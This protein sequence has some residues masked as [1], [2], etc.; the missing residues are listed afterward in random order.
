MK[1]MFRNINT[2]T[3]AAMILWVGVTILLSASAAQSVMISLI[4]CGVVIL[5]SLT[6]MGQ[7]EPGQ[8]LRQ[9]QP[10][11]KFI[12]RNTA[13]PCMLLVPIAKCLAMEFDSPR[14]LLQG[15]QRPPG[16]KSR[17]AA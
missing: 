4:C 14:H 12:N 11:T 16:V 5:G 6:Q 7:I 1:G 2:F 17:G 9:G 13:L 8:K 3:T 15:Q 10:P